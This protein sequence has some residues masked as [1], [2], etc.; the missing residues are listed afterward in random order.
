MFVVS[1]VHSPEGDAEGESGLFNADGDSVNADKDGELDSSISA[2]KKKRKRSK[3]ADE[4]RQDETSVERSKG[5]R[6]RKS[7]KGTSPHSTSDDI[8]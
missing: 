2:P 4:E 3:K 6:S 5:K 8:Y 1:A 7:L